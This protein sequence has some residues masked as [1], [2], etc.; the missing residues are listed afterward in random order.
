MSEPTRFH[1]PTPGLRRRAVSYIAVALSVLAPG[2]FAASTIKSVTVSPNPVTAGASATGTVSF[3]AVE[4]GATVHLSS[5]N[6]AVASVPASITVSVRKGSP[7]SGNTFPV[8]TSAGSVGCTTITAQTTATPPF[9]TLVL[10]PPPSPSSS[11]VVQL[12]LSAPSVAGGQSVTGSLF[13]TQ[14]VTSLQLASSTGSATV[15]ATVSLNPN[16]MGVAVGSFTVNTTRVST[17][18]CA[19]ITATL[20]GSKGR[21]LLKITPLFVG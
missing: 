8:T 7:I 21:A 4:A 19:V 6:A 15:P 5:S 16:E 12:R 3:D 14:P 18:G 17:S 11:D 1:Q 20:G 2:L 13:V 9:S 10:V